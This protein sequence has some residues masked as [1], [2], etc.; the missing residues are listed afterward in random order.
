MVGRKLDL[1]GVELRYVLEG[2][3]VVIY[4]R[5]ILEALKTDV[6]SKQETMWDEDRDPRRRWREKWA[7]LKKKS[8]K[9]SCGENGKE[10]REDHLVPRKE[11][12]GD[13]CF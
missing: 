10:E 2:R 9:G 6:F 5:V 7:K 4:S 11:G 13:E 12:K 3:G 1:T 8:Q